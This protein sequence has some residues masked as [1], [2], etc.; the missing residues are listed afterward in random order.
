MKSR[1]RSRTWV[2]W[3]NLKNWKEIFGKQGVGTVLDSTGS[4]QDRMAGFCVH[5]NKCGEFPFK[6]SNFAPTS[7]VKR[8]DNLGYLMTFFR[9][10]RLYNA[11]RDRRKD[12]WWPGRN[13]KQL[14]V[15]YFNF[16]LILS[17]ILRSEQD[18]NT[19]DQPSYCKG[20][21]LRHLLEISGFLIIHIEC[22]I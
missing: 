4:R 19:C 16:C 3:D 21:L 17:Y 20:K 22:R 15:V 9:L 18:C 8:N 13:F 1:K 11:E 2:Q 6:L 5:D 14:V 7:D 10:Q 12:R